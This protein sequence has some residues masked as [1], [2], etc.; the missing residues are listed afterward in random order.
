M[1]G[2]DMYDIHVSDVCSCSG[3]YLCTH[4][5]NSRYGH[6]YGNDMLDIHVPDVCS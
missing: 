2:N 6:M 3:A 1:Y 4:L 5:E